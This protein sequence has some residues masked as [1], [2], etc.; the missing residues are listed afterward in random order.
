MKAAT[1]AEG[2]ASQ[3]QEKYMDSIE[4]RLNILKATWQ[5]LSNTFMKSD[6]LK[7]LVSSLTGVLSLL[8]TLVNKIGAIPTL[9]TAAFATAAIK[10]VGRD[11]MFSL[12]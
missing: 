11:K 10:K 5:S 4:G 9:L 8:D 1:N 3:E 7:G 6:S 2:T 12:S